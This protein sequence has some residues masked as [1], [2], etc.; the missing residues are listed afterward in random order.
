MI[1]CELKFTWQTL[2]A[3]LPAFRSAEDGAEERDSPPRPTTLTILA[4]EG[5]NSDWLK[6]QGVSGGGGNEA[7]DDDAWSGRNTPGG[8]T[9]QANEHGWFVILSLPIE[10]S[11]EV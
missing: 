6:L 8:A 9:S 7:G 11:I 1:F 2:R 3:K 4:G 10:V 5:I